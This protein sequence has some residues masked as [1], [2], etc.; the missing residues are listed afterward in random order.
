MSDPVRPEL[1]AVEELATLVRHL[2]DELAAFRRR[3][4]VAE[5]RVREFEEAASASPGQLVAS[6]ARVNELEEDN[7]ALRL[8]LDKAANRTQQ[9]L[10]RVH[11]LRQ[12]AQR[13][14][15]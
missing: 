7:A 4:L 12:Q 13:G 2:A 15:P 3:A 8:R 14:E 1:A 5:G 9:L 6:G 10:D 11:F